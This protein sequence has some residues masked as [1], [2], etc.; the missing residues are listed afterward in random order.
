MYLYVESRTVGASFFSRTIGTTT[1]VVT[2]GP[3]SLRAGLAA[4]ALAARGELGTLARGGE[5]GE[6]HGVHDAREVPLAVGAHLE[7]RACARVASGAL[8][9][10]VRRA[11]ARRV[12]CARAPR[13]GCEGAPP[14]WRRSWG[15]LHWQRAAARPRS[16]GRAT[17]AAWRWQAPPAARWRGSRGE[18][19]SPR[20]RRKAA[21]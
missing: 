20:S 3:S 6:V 4:R 18:G 7:S 1:T 17:R 10:R 5:L 14:S 16:P 21:H 13:A 9:E 15:S 8:G 11:R 2:T 19:H 12:R